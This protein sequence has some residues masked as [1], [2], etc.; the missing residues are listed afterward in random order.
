MKGWAS[1][2]LGLL[3][4]PA[5]AQPEPPRQ[6]RDELSGQTFVLVP[7]GCF[8][9][10][11]DA[12]GPWQAGF[13]VR[14]PE[15]DE[16]PRHEVCIDAFWLGETEVTHGHW[17]KVMGAVKLGVH[18]PVTDVAWGDAVAF[19]EKLSVRSGYRFRL[20]TEAEWEYACHAGTYLTPIQPTGEERLALLE[21][22]YEVAWYAYQMGR[23]PKIKE[24]KYRK[25]NAWGLY[26]MLGNAWEWTADDYDPA[27]YSAHAK[28]NPQVITK[29][30]GKVIRGGSYRSRSDKVRCGARSYAPEDQISPVQGFRVVRELT[31]GEHGG[32]VK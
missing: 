16:L 25:P 26:D 1:V 18:D 31:P 4:L 28:H 11:A 21:K 13:P 12:P 14:V 6:W 17:A 23:D 15:A 9:M 22:T 5:M 29:G 8:M 7:A 30:K 19:A 10:G 32:L 3:A 27:G 24:V 2:L 20:P